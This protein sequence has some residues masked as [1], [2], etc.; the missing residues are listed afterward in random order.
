[1][2]DKDHAQFSRLLSDVMAFYKEPMSD[3]AMRIWWSALEEFDLASVSRAFTAHAKDPDRGRFVPKPAD[4]IFQ[5]RGSNDE[6]AMVAWNDVLAQASRVGR[7][8][9][10]E[11]S[12]AQSMA[13]QTLGGWSAICNGSEDELPHMQRRFMDA[14]RVYEARG[15]READ[16]RISSNVKQALK[17]LA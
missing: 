13:V 10:P 6:R 8:S 2:I 5:L 12:D 15:S 16:L 9:R 4:V 17:V 14:Y 11:L 7:Y 3:F 1:M